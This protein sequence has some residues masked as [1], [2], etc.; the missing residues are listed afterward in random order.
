MEDMFPLAINL[1]DT[2]SAP[3]ARRNGNEVAVQ[4]E[5]QPSP[6]VVNSPLVVVN[7]SRAKCSQHIAPSTRKGNEDNEGD[8]VDLCSSDDDGHEATPCRAPNKRKS[9]QYKEFGMMRACFF[10]LMH[11]ERKCVFKMFINSDGHL[12]A[13]TLSIVETTC[14]LEMIVIE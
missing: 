8:I 6:L 2:G 3:I 4:H 12:K 13:T 7:S 9:F 1:L 14:I 11:C 5:S 10:L